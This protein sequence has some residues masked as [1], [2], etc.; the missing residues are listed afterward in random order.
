VDGDNRVASAVTNSGA[1]SDLSADPRQVL[2]GCSASSMVSVADIADRMG[3]SV[4]ID[5][6]SGPFPPAVDLGLTALQRHGRPV[7]MPISMKT[8]R[9]NSVLME[10][11]R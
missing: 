8:S 6:R 2:S 10:N 11:Q 3:R 1:G 4:D 7:E 5:R 9:K